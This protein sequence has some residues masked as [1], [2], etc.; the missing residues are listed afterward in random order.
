MT[1]NGSYTLSKDD[2]QWIYK[3]SKYDKQWII[4]FIKRWQTMDHT[5]YQKMNNH[6]SNEQDDKNAMGHTIF[7]KVDKQL[8]KQMIKR[9]QTMDHTTYLSRCQT[10]E[11]KR[12]QTIGHA[13]D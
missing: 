12:W 8:N 4:H 10:M 13:N 11:I 7:K 9:W 3:L 5:L 2:K 1:N 6:W